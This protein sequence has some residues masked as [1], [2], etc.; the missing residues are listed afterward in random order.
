MQ[1]SLRDVRPVIT[2]TGT[3]TE[4]RTPWTVRGDLL[5]SD[6]GANAFVVEIDNGGSGVLRF[7]DD[8]HGRRP[9]PGT[10]L[11]ART[12]SATAPPATSAPT[13]S[14]MSRCAHRR[15]GP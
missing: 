8:V 12:A 2:M 13:R 9:D 10:S 14:P 1:W 3:A 11:T 6:A 15:S 4:V 5:D 7:G